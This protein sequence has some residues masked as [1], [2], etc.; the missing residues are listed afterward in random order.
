[1]RPRRSSLRHNST[2]TTTVSLFNSRRP[3]LPPRAIRRLLTTCQSGTYL[4]SDRSQSG[5]AERRGR[6]K[7]GGP[8]N[9][10]T[11]AVDRGA[12]RAGREVAPVGSYSERAVPTEQIPRNAPTPEISDPFSGN[13]GPSPIG[14]TRRWEIIRGAGQEPRTRLGQLIQANCTSNVAR[15]CPLKSGRQAGGKRPS[16]G[17]ADS[18]DRT[19]RASAQTVSWIHSVGRERERSESGHGQGHNPAHPTAEMAGILRKSPSQLIPQCITLQLVA[20]LFRSTNPN[21]R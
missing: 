16:C 18:V 8:Q 15:S 2:I 20:R 3:L 12:E 14:R 10:A 19:D 11:A 5:C 1:M 13:A 4:R 21:P 17:D 7:K 9:P 6:K